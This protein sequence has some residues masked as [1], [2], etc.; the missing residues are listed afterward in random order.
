M[1]CIKL[2][3]ERRAPPRHGT[4][5]IAVCKT[6]LQ[7]A[8]SVHKNCGMGTSADSWHSSTSDI[9]FSVQESDVSGT[10]Y[11]PQTRPKS[12]QMVNVCPPLLNKLSPKVRLPPCKMTGEGKIV[13]QPINKHQISV[14]ELNYT[15]PDIKT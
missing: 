6:P 13:T 14:L 7:Q 8:Q 12:P 9:A 3:F 4:C 11:T 15:L 1:H 2:Y 5:G 10:T